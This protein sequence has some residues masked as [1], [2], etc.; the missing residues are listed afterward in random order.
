M[1]SKTQAITTDS[2]L[3]INSAFICVVGAQIFMHTITIE[4]VSEVKYSMEVSLDIYA[5]KDAYDS[6]KVKVDTIQR[7]VTY[8][9]N[10]TLKDVFDALTI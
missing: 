7:V 10:Q 8:T 1:L 4:G 5:S 3:T 2:G 9:E 6:G